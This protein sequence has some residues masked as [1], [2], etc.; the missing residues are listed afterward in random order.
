MGLNWK[1]AKIRYGWTRGRE[2][3][4]GGAKRVAFFTMTSKSVRSGPVKFMALVRVADTR[5]ATKDDH[6]GGIPSRECARNA[7]QQKDLKCRAVKDVATPCAPK[8]KSQSTRVQEDRARV[9]EIEKPPRSTQSGRGGRNG[10]SA[11]FLYE[12]E[13][14]EERHEYEMENAASKGLRSNVRS[15]PNPDLVGR[16]HCHDCGNECL[17]VSPT[18]KAFP[19][20]PA[21]IP[22]IS[23][24]RRFRSD[25][26]ITE[27][28][29]SSAASS[30]R[31][32]EP[33][34]GR[35]RLTSLAEEF[36]CPRPHEELLG[37]VFN[38]PGHLRSC[39][40][41]LPSGN[42]TST[43]IATSPIWIIS[44]FAHSL[45]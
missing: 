11:V 31:S 4:D 45:P 33:E 20:I 15:A 2:S 26:G 44:P 8:T 38:A 42:T 17:R 5:P 32:R 21:D 9:T 36:R 34:A 1:G 37:I 35:F 12:C 41:I 43:R 23:L 18:R 39:R 27:E 16:G 40:E 25:S 6:E 22:W 10:A 30:R 28:W 13:E 19:G 14:A 7:K 24:A 29:L 3:Y